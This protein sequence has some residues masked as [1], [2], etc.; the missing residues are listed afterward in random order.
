[1]QKWYEFGFKRRI[2]SVKILFANA[3]NNQ[4]PAYQVPA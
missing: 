4:V 3:K 1:M 2:L